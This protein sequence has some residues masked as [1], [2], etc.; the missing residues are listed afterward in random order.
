MSNTNMPEGLLNFV[1][2][3]T[4]VNDIDNFENKVIGTG[5]LLAGGTGGF[6][7][8]DSLANRADAKATRKFRRKVR[9]H[10]A[11]V[12][13]QNKI[14]QSRSAGVLDREKA[15][16][17]RDAANRQINRQYGKMKSWRADQRLKK[18]FGGGAIGSLIALMLTNLAARGDN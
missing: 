11:E 15:R 7:I 9:P 13:K 10:E 18:R 12:R 5:A 8:G 16:S 14:L 3:A 4:T 17:A 2:S 1:K 6:M